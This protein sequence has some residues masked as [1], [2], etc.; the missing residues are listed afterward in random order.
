MSNEVP[1]GWVTC[2]FGDAFTLQRGFDLPV[3]DRAG[4]CVPIIASNGQVGSHCAP[5]VSPPGLVTGR[6]GTIGKVIYID[7]P[8]WPL[9]TTLYV[10]N[11][12]GNDARFGYYFLQNFDLG[13]YATGTGV[14]TLNRNDVHAI[15][16]PLPPLPEQ[17]KIAAILT[18]VDEG[19]AATEAL[20]AQTRR[21]KQGVLKLLLTRG[22]GHTRFKQTEIGEI[23]D[24]WEIR[25]L[26]D[27]ASYI[28][29]GSRGWGQFYADR[30]AT[31]IRIANLTREH[32]Y[33]DMES[34][35]FVALP[36]SFKEGRRT[37]LCKGDVLVSITADLGIIGYFDEQAGE[38]YI[39]QHIALIRFSRKDVNALFVAYALSGPWM[40]K[41]IQTLNDQGAKA[42]LNLQTIKNLPVP[43]P[44]LS[45]QVHISTEMRKMDESM[46]GLQ[47]HLQQLVALKYALMSDLLTG[48]KRVSLP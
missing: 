42:G 43:L 14:P 21:V 34:Q 15:E 37:L 39:N 8:F 18:S 4:G 11:F 19:I 38:A 13:R 44:S 22:I 16:V 29:S 5:K 48:R 28:T 23:P 30:G 2:N 36:T 3:Q 25:N 1:E 35:V 47:Q 45:E 32:V 9:N 12:H 27:L 17:K 41:Y 6:S 20:I 40:Q 7:E 33:M 46:F 26:G 10:K 31:F 24:G